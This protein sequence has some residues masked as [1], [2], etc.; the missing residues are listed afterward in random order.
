MMYRILLNIFIFFTFFPYIQVI[1]IPG[2]GDTQPF[3]IL[4]AFFV[5]FTYL[6]KTKSFSVPKIYIIPLIV[7]FFSLI[8]F[9]FSTFSTEAAIRSL[10]GYLSLFLIGVATHIYLKENNGISDKYIK[11]VILIWFIVGAIQTFVYP[12]FLAFL[13][14][15]ASTTFSRG[16]VGLATEPSYYGTVGVFLFFYSLFKLKSLKYTLLTLFQII[17]FAQSA[18]AILLL[19]VFLLVYLIVQR[20]FIILGIMILLIFTSSTFFLSINSTSRAV[21]LAQRAFVQ[22]PTMIFKA[23]ASLN[24]RLG[25]IYFS[26]KGFFL[27]YG[28][29]A[30]FE[31]YY[32]YMTAEGPK[33]DFF[34]ANSAERI[35]SGYGAVL[36]ELGVVGL[37]IPFIFHV[38]ILKFFRGYRRWQIIVSTCFILLMFTPVPIAL[39]YVSFFFS[40]LIHENYNA[41]QTLIN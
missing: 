8:V 21:I 39:P 33:Q 20:K 22:D 23:D 28:A 12:N 35:M 32:Q 29:P 26:V 15:R 18:L 3:S 17:I 30:L 11:T 4:F 36:F 25:A 7:F 37:L 6:L 24:E 19:L 10:V 31:S 34:I 2:T 41:K 13:L 14:P 27:H 16:V 1:Y 38:A 40:F 5:C 9:L